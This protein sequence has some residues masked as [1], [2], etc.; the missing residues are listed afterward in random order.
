MNPEWLIYTYVQFH[1]KLASLKN[2]KN[3]ALTTRHD[4]K[5]AS[6]IGRVNEPI[7]KMHREIGH[8]N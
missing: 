4:A 6:E 1:I 5:S 7:R 2:E 3:V 8:V